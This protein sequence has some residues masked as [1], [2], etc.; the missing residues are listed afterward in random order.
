MSAIF[1]YSL[2]TVLLFIDLLLFCWWNT[3]IHL[4][5]NLFDS[6]KPLLLQPQ[7]HPLSTLP[8]D[9]LHPLDHQRWD[10]LKLYWTGLFWHFCGVTF[11]CV[12]R[13]VGS[14]SL[15]DKYRHNREMLMLL[16]PHRDR[17]SSAMYTNI[18]ENGQ[19]NGGGAKWTLVWSQQ[20]VDFM[21]SSFFYSDKTSTWGRPLL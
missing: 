19:V 2:D 6:G 10:P 5:H 3:N 17:P 9:Q 12:P 14:P 13:A 1:N 15:P 20:D 8:D 16:P 21:T 7:L 4:H 11:V 18:I